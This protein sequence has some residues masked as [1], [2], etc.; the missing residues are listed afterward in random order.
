MFKIQMIKGLSAVKDVHVGF[1]NRSCATV[2]VRIPFMSYSF[3][4]VKGS[5]PEQLLP[6]C[7]KAHKWREDL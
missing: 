6:A 7:L 1:F 3:I 5:F 4:S 2:V